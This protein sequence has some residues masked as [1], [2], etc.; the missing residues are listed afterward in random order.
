MTTREAAARAVCALK[1]VNPDCM[2]QNYADEPVDGY[3]KT[4]SFHGGDQ[5]IPAHFGWRN[6]LAIVDAVIGALSPPEPT[7]VAKCVC[8]CEV[9]DQVIADIAHELG[10]DPDNERILETIRSLNLR[11][12]PLQDHAAPKGWKLVPAL[13]T[14]AMRDTLDYNLIDNNSDDF[15]DSFLGDH[16]CSTAAPMLAEEETEAKS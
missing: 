2:H 1:G 6:Q 10:C 9:F 11:A 14:D 5:Q 4:Y 13:L 16:G 7:E 15:W 8:G 12:M 3:I